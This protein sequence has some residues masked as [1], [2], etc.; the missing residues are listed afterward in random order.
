MRFGDL[1]AMTPTPFADFRSP[2]SVRVR[3][4]VIFS[5]SRTPASAARPITVCRNQP[6]WPPTM[7]HGALPHA[8]RPSM[9]SALPGPSTALMTPTAPSLS[10]SFAATPCSVDPK[11]E[12]SGRTR[13]IAILPRTSR[14]A[15]SGAAPWPR[16]TIGAV[17]VVVAP[18]GCGNADCSVTSAVPA[19]NAGSPSSVTLHVCGDH[20]VPST[21]NGSTRGAWLPPGFE[22][23][24][25]RLDRVLKGRR[26]GAAAPEL[27]AGVQ[28]LERK[29]DDLLLIGFERGGV[30]QLVELSAPMR[31]RRWQRPERIVVLHDRLAR[32][33]EGRRGGRGGPTPPLLARGGH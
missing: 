19:P 13:T 17:N 15:R 14:P 31:K 10:T 22:L 23:G 6:S 29:A 2:C 9:Y 16:Y 21:A 8:K 30:Q 24:D 4:R 7:K 11:S 20:M 1:P 25:D 5:L 33:A 32:V 3:A 18:P 12:G 27:V 26:R 28:T